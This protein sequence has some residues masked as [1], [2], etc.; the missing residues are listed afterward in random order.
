M[1]EYTTAHLRNVAVLGHGNSGKTSLL[2]ACLYHTGTAKRCGSVD[3]GTS[4]LDVLPEEKVRHLTIEM[5]LAACEWGEE[6]LNLLDTPGYPDF[7]GEAVSAV[8]AA[9]AALLVLSA[10][11][12]I[13]VETEKFWQ[14]ARGE[15]LPCAFF[16]NKMDREHADFAAV[17]DELRVRFGAGVVPVQLPIGQ[18]AAFQGVVD[19]LAMHGK[20]VPHDED[21]CVVT[22]I[23]EYLAADVE[24]ARQTLIEAVADYDNALMEK[25]LEGE[26]IEEAEVAEALVQGVCDGKIFPVFCGSAK[27]DIGVKKLL[28]GIA[29]YLPA[30]AATV[31]GTEPG[32]GE[33]VERGISGAFSAQAFKTVVDPQSG[34]QTY[35][36]IET[37]TLRGDTTVLDVTTGRAERIGSLSTLRGRQAHTVTLAHAGDIVVTAKLAAVRTGDTLAAKDAPIL[38]EL[39]DFPAP[40][41]EMA[42]VT[43]KKEEADKLLAA[44]AKEQEQQQ[45]L[46]VHREEA[47]QQ[48][49]VAALGEMQLTVLAEQL[50]RKYHVE[51]KLGRPRVAYRETIRKAAQAEGKFKKQSGGHG[52]FGHVVLEVQPQEAGTGNAFSESIFGGSVPR[53]YIP[54]VEKGAAETLARGILAGF[55][56]VDVAVRLTDGSYH[57]VDSSEAAFK[58]ATAIA[59]RRAVLAANP[60]LLEPL[61]EIAVTTPEYYLGDVIGRLN[62]KR[63]RILGTEMSGKDTTVLHAVVPEAELYGYATELRSQTQGRGTF[64]RSF[65]R[66]EE[67]PE[68]QAREI[69]EAK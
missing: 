6:K 20:V 45:T 63:A 55:P 65:L 10:P 5:K 30:P 15:D 47:L 38:Y 33:L 18:E 48:T 53:Q 29:A 66:Y 25:Y 44:L 60:V 51:L 4:L 57:P 37:G 17:V 67:M 61:D 13:E 32:T 36:R 43:E 58:A 1:K 14:L 59:L 68:R 50:A 22:E 3:E 54:A 42:V 35:L 62:G 19:L 49:V 39:P 41:L 31:L 26:P 64:T 56:V 69:L 28:G 7:F 46:A 11:A 9:D 16:L 23:P 21:D 52:Q 2:D 12:G 40:M 24:A 27:A 34:R 8:A